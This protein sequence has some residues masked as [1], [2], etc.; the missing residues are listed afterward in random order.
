MS[1]ELGVVCWKWQGRPDYRSKFTANTVNVLRSMVERNFKAPHRFFCVTEDAEGLDKRIE[2]VKGWNDF[3]DVPSPH[4]NHNPSCYRRLRMFSPEA[5]STFGKR[6]VSLDLD[7][8]VV[9][10][11]EPLWLRPE[12]FV[13]WGDTNPRTLYNGSMV[14]MTAGAR[15]QVWE[16]FDPKTSPAEAKASGNFGSDQAWISHVLGPNEAKWTKADG[17]Y[18]FRNEV[19]RMGGNLPRNA[20]IVM[21]HGIFDPW[22]PG[23]QA[24]QWVKRNWC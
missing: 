14:L 1:D 15:K 10:K 16:K 5:E 20:R 17:V 19:Q 22:A 3:A 4:G 12:E 7:C 21:F 13:I 9:G 24:L 2:V 8:V 23:P 6:F 18:S 11:L